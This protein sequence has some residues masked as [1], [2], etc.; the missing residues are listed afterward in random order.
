MFDSKG[1]LTQHCRRKST[2]G[3]V[4]AHTFVQIQR[5]IC[6]K[7]SDTQFKMTLIMENLQI[8]TFKEDPQIYF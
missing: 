7:S 4:G 6:P 3:G 5:E 1:K 2:S 8:L